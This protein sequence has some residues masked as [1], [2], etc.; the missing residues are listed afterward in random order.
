MLW[1][2]ATPGY[3][4]GSLL[5]GCLVAWAGLAPFHR[6][7]VAS[8]AAVVL[9]RFLALAFGASWTSP[10]AIIARALVLVFL[11]AAV[12]IVLSG[13]DR[14]VA[15]HAVF[16][17]SPPVMPA[18]F[19]MTLALA[20]PS[21]LV[22]DQLRA[23]L[24]VAPSLGHRRAATFGGAISSGRSGGD[25]LANSVADDRV[26]RPISR[27][28]GPVIVEPSNPTLLAPEPRPAQKPLEQPPGGRRD[29][30]RQFRDLRAKVMSDETA[31]RLVAYEIRRR[32]GID[33]KAAIAAAIER[34]E[35]ERSRD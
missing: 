2:N 3:G 9:A 29:N 31:E 10:P 17:A 5:T 1:I 16:V 27:D 28:L 7:L 12:G 18:V 6:L 33:R 13:N 8:L 23:A 26:K 11:V 4:P 21:F 15:W 22:A 14:A 34:L 24:V 25:R 20:L 32:P 30:S 19:A 35:W